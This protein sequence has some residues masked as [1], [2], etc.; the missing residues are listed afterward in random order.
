[1]GPGG[2]TGLCVKDERLPPP[3][4]AEADGSSAGLPWV[5]AGTV[6]R[7]QGRSS[8][9]SRAC[10]GRAMVPLGSWPVGVSYRE[11]L[12]GFGWQDRPVA[13]RQGHYCSLWA[14][15]ADQPRDF[16]AGKGSC[17]LL[18]WAVVS[19]CPRVSSIPG[20]C[21]PCCRMGQAWGPE[22]RQEILWS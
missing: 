1:M 4:L 17:L 21:L 22:T 19:G 14:S 11:G 16:E 3:T 12:R 9:T 13:G 10:G 6:L 5:R 15:G 2:V 8:R 18:G 7:W 20:L